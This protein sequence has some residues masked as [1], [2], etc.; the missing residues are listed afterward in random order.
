[1]KRKNEILELHYKSIAPK[2][3]IKKFLENQ[4]QMEQNPVHQILVSWTCHQTF[5]KNCELNK[6]GELLE[7][8]SYPFVKQVDCY[9]LD[10]L[11]HHLRN[12]I[13]KSSKLGMLVASNSA[14]FAFCNSTASISGSVM[15]RT[16]A[17][18]TK[19]TN[20]IQECDFNKYCDNMQP[21]CLIVHLYW[22]L[23]DGMSLIDCFLLLHISQK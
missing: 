5:S 2:N 11:D 7:S 1:M 20:A 12:V 19:K 4:E 18:R 10:H 23:K 15:E 13:C 6:W 3:S 22:K 16:P 8:L 9:H 17:W 14:G 21:T